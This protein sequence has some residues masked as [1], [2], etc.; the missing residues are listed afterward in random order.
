WH[1]IY[2]RVNPGTNSPVRLEENVWVGDGA[3]ICKGVTIGK[4][5][6]IGASAVVVNNIPE[7][8][9]AAGNPAKPVKQLDPDA[10]FTKRSH[11][12]SNPERLNKEIEQLDRYMLEGN[13][14]KSWFRY[15]INP[16]KGD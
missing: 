10:V 9:V 14:F 16:R 1:G 3:V 2:D 7:N 4:N 13:T 12:F 6:V 8:T 11:W 5:S 15:L